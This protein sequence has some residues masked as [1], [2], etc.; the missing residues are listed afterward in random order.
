MDAC[1]D[2][3]T[4]A[5]TAKVFEEVSGKKVEI[6]ELTKEEFLESKADELK[7]KF[8]EELWIQYRMFLFK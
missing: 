3:L 5:E 6:L 1:S 8:T 2:K 4:Y 7:S